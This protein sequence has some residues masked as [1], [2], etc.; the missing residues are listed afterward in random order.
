MALTSTPFIP[1]PV[2][3]GAGLL[4]LVTFLVAGHEHR[5]RPMAETQGPTLA[6]RE[7]RF[8][9]RDDGA[10]AVLDATSGRLVEALHGEQGFVRGVLRGLAQERLRR[11]SG[12]ERPFL[13]IVD[14]QQRLALIDP[15]SNRR[16]DLESFGRDNAAIFARWLAEPGAPL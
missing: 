4:M 16:V 11:G 7:L 1:R 2:L 14:G 15:V 9:D 13:L 8:V 6:L 5:T 3:L 12:A 10:V